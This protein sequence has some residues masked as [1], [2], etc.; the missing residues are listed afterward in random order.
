M[1]GGEERCW[2]FVLLFSSAPKQKMHEC[3]PLSPFHSPTS[4]H[5][6]EPT[7]S[8]NTKNLKVILVNRVLVEPNL[9]LHILGVVERILEFWECIRLREFSLVK[10]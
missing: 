6:T 5:Q 3:M 8:Q 4:I 9:H 7:P 10:E 2:Y 1:C